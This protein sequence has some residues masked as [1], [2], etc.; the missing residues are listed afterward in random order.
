MSEVQNAQ[1]ADRFS[2][3]VPFL[4]LLLL[5]LP[6]H[7]GRGDW[8]QQGSGSSTRLHK[9]VQDGTADGGGLLTLEIWPRTRVVLAD[10]ETFVISGAK[11]VWRL[12]TNRRGWS[13]EDVSIGGIAVPII[14]AL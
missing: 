1:G 6:Q 7:H 12:N 4:R 13:L 9:I 2:P 5:L 10:D 3:Q 11:G 14:E 8:L